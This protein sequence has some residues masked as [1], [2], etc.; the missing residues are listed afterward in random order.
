MFRIKQR[1][2]SVFVVEHD[3]EVI[4]AAEWII[5]MGPLAGKSGGTIVYS[6]APAG[7]S[8]TH[9]VTGKY[10]LHKDE[11]IHKRK[12]ASSFY[13]I[14]NASA[15]NLRNVSVKIPRGVLTCVTGVSGSGK[16][17][18][19]HECFAKQHPEAIVIDQSPIGKTSRANTATFIGAFDLIRKE[20]AA[21]TGMNASLFSFNSG[22][23]CP[24]C[25]GQ[26]VITFELH[27]LDSVKTVCDECE[28]K[29]YHSEILTV[30]CN[31]KNIAEVLDMTISQASDFFKSTKI[32]RLLE[33]LEDV[34]LG[35]L[36]LGQS[37]STL[38]GGESQ[39]LKIATE[40]KKEGNIYIMDEPTT[41]LHMS[42]I[43]TLRGIIKSLV[44]GNN[45]V[46]VIE[47]NLD[48]VKFADWIIDMGPEGGKKGGE[49]LFQGVPEDLIN[50]QQSITGKYLKTVL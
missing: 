17:S 28:G 41:G 49:L 18:L 6:G 37:L 9:S 7:L 36:K 16:S 50:C 32:K 15:N 11:C 25:S 13:E 4:R 44:T 43:A 21:A 20:F 35:Y 30:K 48:I 5:D 38:S 22:G 10:L 42:D 12:S 40:L 8:A 31:G 46:I 45:T 19:I 23:A 39:R 2:N 33:L 1:G 26:G 3:P 47:H 24:K 34:G 14:K 29:R 27:F